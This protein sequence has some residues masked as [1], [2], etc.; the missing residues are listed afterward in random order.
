MIQIA[1]DAKLPIL[2]EINNYR[3]GWQAGDLHQVLN[4]PAAR[5]N[6][7]DNIHQQHHGAQVRR[8]SISTSSSFPRKTRRKMV[9]FMELLSAKLKPPG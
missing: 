8:A 3:E 5:E 4:D 7:I 6:L 2:A 1:R 9:E